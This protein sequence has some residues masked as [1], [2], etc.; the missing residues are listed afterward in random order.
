MVE[1]LLSALGKDDKTSAAH[2]RKM[3]VGC[4]DIAWGAGS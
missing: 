3:V 4:N 1:K 2:K